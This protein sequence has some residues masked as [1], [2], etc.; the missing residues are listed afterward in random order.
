MRPSRR[1]L[2]Q[3]AGLSGVGLACVPWMA[4]AEGGNNHKFLFVF[5]IGGWDTAHCFSP[6]IPVCDYPEGSFTASAADISYVSVGAQPSVDTFFANHASR[7]CVVHG[8]E[9]R[10]VAHD[11]CLRLVMT[12]NSLPGLDDWPSTLAALDPN[13]RLMPALHLGGPS[14]VG[15]YSSSVVRTGTNGQLPNL[16]DNSATADQGQDTTW[17]GDSVE[18][19]E[20][21]YLRLR[22]ETQV[23]AAGRGREAG[24]ADGAAEIASRLEDLRALGEELELRVGN[25]L[26]DRMLLAAE[27]MSQGVTRTAMVGH[28][29]AKGL[30]WDTHVANPLLQVD[31]YEELFGALDTLVTALE[32]LPGE[33]GALIDET[34][35]VVM[36]EMGRYPT[37]N[38]SNGKDHWTFTSAMLIGGGIAGG[39]EVGAYNEYLGG[40]PVDLSSGDPTDSG[41]LLLPGHLGATLLALGGHDPADHVDE[42]AITACLS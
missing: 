8:L 9:A 26:E 4:R 5:A 14:Y 22:H 36:S 32:V 11:A 13:S 28:E 42:E 12:G 2:L 29:G 17:R 39:R 16:L 10:S 25:E 30:S 34:T 27:A 41:T 15:R 3:L 21:E 18:A 24:L 37:L 33:E 40:R 20:E 38:A 6:D 19:L 31:N 23:L 35:V 7:T 1:R